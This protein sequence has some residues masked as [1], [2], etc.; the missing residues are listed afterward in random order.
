MN[1]AISPKSVNAVI[2][3]SYNYD[4][5]YTDMACAWSTVY[6]VFEIESANIRSIDCVTGCGQTLDDAA[7]ELNIISMTD[8]IKALY[9]AAVERRRE[10][11][12]N[13]QLKR[14]QE[15]LDEYN[16]KLLPQKKGQ[17]VEILAGRS[18]GYVGKVTWFGKNKFNNSYSR[19]HL[20]INAQAIIAYCSQ[21]PYS[22]PNSGYDLIA[23]RPI[24]TDKFPNGKEIIYIDPTNSRV[25]EGYEIVT[26][27]EA[28]LR[29][30]VIDNETFT[31]KW[32]GAY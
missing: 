28:R 10:E 31:M 32:R 27:D 2:I 14:F 24:D 16:G 21:K 13:D 25:I 29:S 20:S 9:E 22:I 5:K 6:E 12:F 1:T 30:M 3:S 19:N 18:K 26:I 7:P 15:E 11:R 8:E 17:I 4:H 23:V